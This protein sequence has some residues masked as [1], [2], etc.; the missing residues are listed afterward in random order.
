VN[1]AAAHPI[2]VSALFGAAD[3]ARLDAERRTHFPPERNHL[4]AHLTLFHHLPP[5]LAH[6]LDRRLAEEAQAPRPPATIAAPMTLG[7][8]VAWR[9]ESVA[10]EALRARLADAFSGLLTPQDAAPWRPHVTIQNKVSAR[11]ADAL[12]RKLTG[13][14]RA[15]PLVIAGLAAWEYE[16]GPWRLRKRYPFRG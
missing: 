10:L 9:V 15:H 13:E 12:F 11:E 5:S 7:Q 16:G 1:G 14:F 8:G 4:P 6:E 2:I 3:F